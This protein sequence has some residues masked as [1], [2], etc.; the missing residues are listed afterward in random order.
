MSTITQLYFADSHCSYNSSIN[1]LNEFLTV[2]GE[3]ALISEQVG[4]VFN[5]FTPL[6]LGYGNLTNDLILAIIVEE[7]C[8]IERRLVQAIIEERI[9]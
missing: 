6:P 5:L 8:I 9:S 3:G 1:L 4:L 7:V 2:F